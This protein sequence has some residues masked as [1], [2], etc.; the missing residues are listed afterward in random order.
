M[1]NL[2]SKQMMP[3]FLI[4]ITNSLN[5]EEIFKTDSLLGTKISIERFRGSNT[6]LNAETAMVSIIERTPATQRKPEFTM[7][8]PTKDPENFPQLK[9]TYPLTFPSTE[10]RATYANIIASKPNRQRAN[11]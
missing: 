5:A 11:Q 8:R 2:R 4:K 10:N 3:L 6:A 1:T 9:S 7:K